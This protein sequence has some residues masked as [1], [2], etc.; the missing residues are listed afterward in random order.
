MAEQN[1][2]GKASGGERGPRGAAVSA[3]G[4]R[5][6]EAVR[7]RKPARAIL[8]FVALVVVV[9]LFARV[10]VTGSGGS[11]V[12]PG[13]FTVRQD[14]LIITVTESGSIKARNSIDIKSEVEGQA[15]IIS[16]VPE[17]SYITQ[18]DVDNGKVLVELDSSRSEEQLAQREIDFAGAEASYTEAKEAYDIRLKQNESDITAAELDVKFDLMDIK[19]YLG[20]IV[21]EKLVG[22]VNPAP[23]TDI[24]IAL[25][26]EQPDLG[27]EALQRLRELRADIDL[28]EEELKQT[29]S[30]LEWTQKLYEKEYVSLNELEADRLREQ[31]GEIWWEQAKTA[32]ASGR[33]LRSSLAQDS[34]RLKSAEAR[35]EL[36]KGRLDKLKRQI[37]AC[38]MK[39]PAPG[40]VIYSS[41][42]DPWK[43][44]REGPIEP[45]SVVR[46][47]Q[48]IITL[49]DTTGMIVEINVHESSVVKVRPGQTAKIV[50]A[51]F[52]D[53]TLQGEV[54][55]VALLPDPQ[56]GWLSP[57]LKVY[58]TEVSID[59]T[60]DFLKSG[61]SAKV[62]V[63]IEQL[64]DVIIVPVQVVANRGGKKVC[65]CLT[66]QGPEPREVLTGAFN[67]IFVQITDGLEVG[68]E[69][70]LNPPRL[71]EPSGAARWERGRRPP[72]DGDKESG[73]DKQRQTPP[74]DGDKESGSDRRKR[75]GNARGPQNP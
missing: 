35:F 36:Q 5:L 57:D 24:D 46:E 39:A 31:R 43:R 22:V 62:E 40:L 6:W 61:M 56:R 52:P 53:K 72:Q 27:G 7:K 10:M 58:T 8:I 54:L 23:D 38:K 51:A 42:G 29:K 47:R 28:R 68:E 67:D 2:T 32:R 74:Q 63:L 4:R 21:A 65:Y 71:I 73:S 70:L 19:K 69:V 55:K 45:G 41:S 33:I 30:T 13:T 44:R 66:P 50:M 25:L 20:E 12:N 9:A 60:Y 14:D 17:G 15:T 34:A 37:D 16:I 1:R 48:T 64:D 75:A 18:E 3:A 49:P 59:G 11:S 26:L